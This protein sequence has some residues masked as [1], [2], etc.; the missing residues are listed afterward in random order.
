MSKSWIKIESNSLFFQKSIINF[1]NLHTCKKVKKYVANHFLHHNTA[2]LPSHTPTLTTRQCLFLLFRLFPP[3]FLL[4]YFT[5]ILFSSL[6]FSGKTT[7]TH[8]NFKKNKSWDFAAAAQQQTLHPLLHCVSTNERMSSDAFSLSTKL[9]IQNITTTF[10]LPQNFFTEHFI[11]HH[12]S[13]RRSHAPI[14]Q[15]CRVLWIVSKSCEV[16]RRAVATCRLSFLLK[17][18]AQRRGGVQRI[19]LHHIDETIVNVWCRTWKDDAG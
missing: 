10:A 17:R 5:C 14:T 16:M 18:G 19:A 4:M 1:L 9:K 2:I 12:H 13:G 3:S 6:R 11:N 7:H 8:N 15:R